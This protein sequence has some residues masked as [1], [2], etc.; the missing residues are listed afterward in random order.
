MC[1]STVW[2]D[3]VLWC[4]YCSCAACT[5]Y[6]LCVLCVVL[7]PVLSVKC[8]G[9]HGVMYVWHFIY[10]AVFVG[11]CVCDVPVLYGMH[12]VVEYCIIN[13]CGMYV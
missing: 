12:D 7:Y 3:G 1:V 9:E 8:S 10:H 5:T 2:H 4:V 11:F 6:L 13:M